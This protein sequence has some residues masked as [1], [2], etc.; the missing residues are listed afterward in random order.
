MVKQD[1]T[2]RTPGT[3]AS[4]HHLPGRR[5]GLRPGSLRGPYFGPQ[6]DESRDPPP[7]APSEPPPARTEDEQREPSLKPKR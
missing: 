6:G 7:N 2:E 1:P 5:A 3:G 4:V